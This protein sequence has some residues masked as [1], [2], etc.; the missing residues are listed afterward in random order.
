MSVS[1][2]VSCTFQIGPPQNGDRF[3]VVSFSAQQLEKGGP[4][5]HVEQLE[6][7]RFLR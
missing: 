3:V 2:L 6:E 1:V 5:A 4:E 7:P